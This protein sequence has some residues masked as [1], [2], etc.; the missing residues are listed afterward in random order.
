MITE[1]TVLKWMR[2]RLASGNYDSAAD[3][4]RQFLQEHQIDNTL[5][6]EFACVMEVGFRLAPEIATNLHK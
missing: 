3:L 4:A 1:D 5:S 6:P 2:R